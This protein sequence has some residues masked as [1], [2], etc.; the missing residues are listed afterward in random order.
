MYHAGM[1]PRGTRPLSDD[2]PFRLDPALPATAYQNLKPVKGMLLGVFG[3]AGKRHQHVQPTHV[4][5]VNLDYTADHLT[6]L[7]GP[8]K[9]EVFDATLRTWSSTTA[10][11]VELRLPPGGGKLVR[12]KTPQ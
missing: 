2:V 4:L 5:V 10:D 9:L 11:R 12:I 8:G 6:N 3:P 1:T 7:I